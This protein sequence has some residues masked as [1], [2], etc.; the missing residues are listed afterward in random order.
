MGHDTGGIT[1]MLDGGTT[2][3]FAG[4]MNVEPDGAAKGVNTGA[5]RRARR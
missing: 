1:G 4:A 3:M 2:G 5:E